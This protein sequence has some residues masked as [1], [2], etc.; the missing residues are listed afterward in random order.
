[1][2]EKRKKVKPSKNFLA[3]LEVWRELDYDAWED[4]DKKV[5]KVAYAKLLEEKKL[6]GSFQRR[7]LIYLSAI[8]DLG[9][10]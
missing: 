2:K 9:G 7:L 4:R 10:Q 5:P 1:M 3:Q 6:T 8:E